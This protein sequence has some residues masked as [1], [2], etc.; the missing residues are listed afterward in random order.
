M[1]ISIHYF[2][3]M[4]SAIKRRSGEQLKTGAAI[5]AAVLLPD[6]SICGTDVSI[7]DFRYTIP[8]FTIGFMAGRRD[9]ALVAPQSRN[10]HQPARRYQRRTRVFTFDISNTSISPVTRRFRMNLSTPSGGLFQCYW[11]DV[12]GMLRIPRNIEIGIYGKDSW[13]NHGW[14]IIT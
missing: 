9:F 3:R 10:F 4:Q 13:Q 8:P 1:L 12:S 5:G 14:E 7:L 6:A 2:A 11:H